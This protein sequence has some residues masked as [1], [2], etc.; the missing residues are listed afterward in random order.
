MGTLQNE[1]SKWSKKN[2][3]KSTSKKSNNIKRKKEIFS[4]RDIEDL[5]GIRRPRYERG[6]GGAYRQK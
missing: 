6:S 3:M 5:M 4:Q 2:N 1:L